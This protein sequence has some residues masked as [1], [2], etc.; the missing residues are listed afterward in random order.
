MSLIN[1]GDADA[2]LAIFVISNVWGLVGLVAGAIAGLAI[3]LA[4]IAKIETNKLLTFLT[5]VKPLL[6]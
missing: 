4:L 3:V 2:I 1:N 5:T 6:S